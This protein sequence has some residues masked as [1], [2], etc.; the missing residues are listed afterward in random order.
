[1]QSRF[2]WKRVCC[3]KKTRTENAGSQQGIDACIF[4]NQGHMNIAFSAGDAGESVIHYGSNDLLQLIPDNDGRDDMPEQKTVAAEKENDRKSRYT[5]FISYRHLTPDEEVAKKLH[6]QIENFAVPSGLRRKLGR[7]K[8]G[9]VFRDQEELPLSADLGDD[10]HRALEESEWLICICSPRYLKSRWCMAELRYFLSLGRRDHVLTV[11]T[12][13]EP[14][15]SF[16]EELRYVTV[17]GKAVEKEP[18]AADVRAEDLDGMLKKLK[19]EKLRIIAPILGV[20]YDDLRQRSRRRRNRIIASLAA[21][22]ITLLAG[23]LGYAL[24]KNRVIS[25]ERNSALAAESQWL[26]QSSREALAGGDRMLSLPG[27]IYCGDPVPSSRR[28]ARRGPPD[29]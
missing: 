6:T 24:V 10:I 20:N 8:T 13:G 11:L 3:G 17:D 9:R 5:A 15:E 16:P 1:M 22:A 25:T 23:F 18:L 21:A 4:N 12:E 26:S 2:R 28:T 29:S 14:E 19:R 7:K 27:R